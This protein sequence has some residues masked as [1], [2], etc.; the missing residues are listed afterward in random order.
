MK[1]YIKY[2]L[3]LIVLVGLIALG[4]SQLQHNKQIMK[5]N[6]ALGSQKTL[7][8]PVTVVKPKFEVL[9]QSFSLNGVFHPI[10]SLHLLSDISGR[11]TEHKLVD[12]HTVSKGQLLVQVVN[13]QIDMENDQMNID[14]TLANQL[15]EKAKTDLAKLEAMLE[16][17]AATKQ[18]VEDQKMAVKN[19]ESRIESLKRK[20]RSTTIEAPLS[21]IVH[22]SYL[23]IGS[24]IAPGANLAEIIDISSLKM[25]VPVLDRDVIKLAIGQTIT[26]VPDLFPDKPLKGRITY[27]ASKGDAARNFNIEIQV[28]NNG[29]LKAGMTGVA[30]FESKDQLNSL[31]IPNKCIVGGLQNPQVFVLNGDVAALKP[32]QIGHVQGELVEVLNGLAEG[33]I[34]VETG[35]LNIVNG[36]KVQIIENK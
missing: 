35:Q 4:Y 23:E 20:P 6:A 21:G 33:D 30:L 26:V 10:R 34:V 7:I 32:I 25:Q 19:A 27:I 15:L 12:G 28:V 9:N 14:R 16:R 22:K 5:E 36:S 17:D 3:Y 2:A 1:T 24:F 31:V 8:F 13:E 29:L 11:V 18:Q